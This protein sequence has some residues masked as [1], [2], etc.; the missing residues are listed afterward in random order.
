MT[1][2]SLSSFWLFRKGFP[3]GATWACLTALV[4][5]LNDVI[6]RKA[7]CRLNGLEISFFRFL[8]SMLTVLPFML[9]KG[10]DSFKTS[11]PKLHV[12]R[13]VLG[14]AAIALYTFAVL[15]LPLNEVTTF[16]FTQPFFVLPLAALFLGEKSHKNRWIAALVGF[17]GILIVLNPTGDQFN[18][19]GFIPMGAAFLFAG[20]DVLAKRMVSSETTMTLLFYFA[21]GTTLAAL[22]AALVVWETPT[23]TELFWLFLLGSG[24]NLIQVCLFRAF[25]AAEASSLAPFRY[26][27][28]IFASL[29]GYFLFGEILKFN[30]VL[31]AII[32]IASTLYLTYSETLLKRS[33]KKK[34]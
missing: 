15:L 21:L 13:A 28:L 32:I 20:L 6:A 3:Q 31:G 11:N 14:V 7:G 1:S 27:E 17:V 29:F 30:T 33:K 4:S 12:Y 5:I 25:H 8:F 24:A 22:P 9:Y 34:S 23:L 19:L 16:S 10:L 18:V 2:S 26:V